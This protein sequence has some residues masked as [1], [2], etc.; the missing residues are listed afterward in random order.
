MAIDRELVVR[1]ALRLLDEDGLER[2]SLRRL[3]TELNVKAP[4]LYWHFESKRALLDHMADAVLA[5]AV[6][7]IDVEADWPVWLAH[8]AEVLRTHLLAHPDG[9]QLALGANLGRAPALLRFVERTVEVLHAAGFDLPDASRVAG[10]FLWFVV[11]RTVEEQTLPDRA[12]IQRM[13]DRQPSSILGR[14]MAERGAPDDQDVSFRLGVRIMIAGME[15]V[16]DKE[17]RHP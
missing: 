2:L 7:E 8:T 9:A 11:G 13:A 14:A 4:A 10:S 15:S 12:A 3:A 5:P 6:P 1:T 16:L 17:I